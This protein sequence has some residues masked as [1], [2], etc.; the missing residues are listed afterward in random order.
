MRNV[1]AWLRSLQRPGTVL[2]ILLAASSAGAAFDDIDVSPRARGMGDAQV[3]VAADAFAPYFNPAALATFTN[4]ALGTSYVRPYAL[5]FVDLIYAGGVV[6][7]GGS[8][9]GVGFGL[10][11]LGADWDYTDPVTGE[12]ESRDLI[13]ETTF[14][15]SHGVPLYEDLHS[16]VRLG[17]SLNIYNLKLG[18]TVGTGPGGVLDPGSDTVVGLDAG[19][20]VTLHERTRLGVLARNLNNPQIGRMEEEL[21]QRVIAGVAYEPYLGVVT[22]FEFANTLGEDTQYR[23]GIEFLLPAGLALRFGALTNPSKVT[24]G[25]GYTVA[26]LQLGYA[27]STGGGTLDGSHQFGLTYSWGGETP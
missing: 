3:A 19:L 1:T 7:L 22:T 14:T 12:S 17:Y 4:P 27:Y 16:A 25:F 21:P 13:N 10:R 24:G 9:G 15:L 26:G 20:L 18:A 23:G 2:A 8:L 6:P 5:A 11:R